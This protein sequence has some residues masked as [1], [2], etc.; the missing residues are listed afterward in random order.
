MS[1]LFAKIENGELIDNTINSGFS[2]R[3]TELENVISQ[4]LIGGEN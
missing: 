3:L 4:L 1:I 2:E